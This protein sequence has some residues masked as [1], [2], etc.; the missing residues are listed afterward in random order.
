MLSVA[1]DGGSVLQF[2]ILRA[3][4]IMSVSIPDPERWILTQK[5]V[6]VVKISCF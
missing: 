3:T 5:T 4:L 1:G 2:K 6:F